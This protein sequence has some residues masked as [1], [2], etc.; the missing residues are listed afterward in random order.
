M[1]ISMRP[2]FETKDRLSNRNDG[3]SWRLH[4]SPALSRSRLVSFAACMQ[5]SS[6]I[7]VS[8]RQGQPTFI[9]SRRFVTWPADIL[10]GKDE[11]FKFACLAAILLDQL[12]IRPLETRSLDGKACNDQAHL[13]TPGLRSCRILFI[14]S[15]EESHLKDILAALDEARRA[16]RQ[17]HAGFHAARRNDSV[18]PWRRPHSFRC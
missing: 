9:T 15:T 5:A 13:E 18:S 1:N 12:S 4:V 2:A 11:S 8:S 17:R 7:Q 10:S 6:R 14:S 3:Q 16:D